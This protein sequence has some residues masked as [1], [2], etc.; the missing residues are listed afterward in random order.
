MARAAAIGLALMVMLPDLAS[1]QPAPTEA[2][3]A[4]YV[5]PETE[6][7]ALASSEGATYRIF[8][9]RPETPPPPG[10]F[11]VVYVLD[12]NA[13]FASFAEARRLQKSLG[14][15]A[16]Q[17][18]I[19]GVGYPINEPFDVS[20]RMFDLTPMPPEKAPAAQAGMAQFRTGG[21]DAFARFLLDKL[22]PEIARRFQ[23]NAARQA[24][25]GHSLGGLFALHMLYTRPEAFNAIVAASPS[26]WWN[27]QAILKEER[28]FAA[29]LASAHPPEHPARLLVMVGEREEPQAMVWDATAL[30]RRLEPLSG[31]GLRSQFMLLDGESHLSVPS[32][33]VSAAL[34][35]TLSRP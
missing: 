20:R 29:T 21:Q 14:Q 26:Q 10:G 27:D 28:A 22:R 33:M 23:V 19:V 11:P 2:A 5:L 7:F 18:I 13:I 17:A 32:R 9:S 6:V 35:F 15:A 24:L 16:D 12:G 34:R 1:A 31:N 4:G 25:I 30:A 8:V 3:P